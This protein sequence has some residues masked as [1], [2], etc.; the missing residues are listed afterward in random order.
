[1]SMVVHSWSLVL[2][3]K[4]YAIQSF[5]EKPATSADIFEQLYIP[6]AGEADRQSKIVRLIHIPDCKDTYMYSTRVLVVARPLHLCD[7]TLLFSPRIL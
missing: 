5:T 6:L 3:T 7:I 4:K 1:M 2:Q